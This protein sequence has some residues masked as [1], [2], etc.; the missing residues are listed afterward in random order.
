[1]IVDTDQ[2][3]SNEKLTM[4]TSRYHQDIIVLESKNFNTQIKAQYLDDFTQELKAH[5]KLNQQNNRLSGRD[6]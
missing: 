4:P 6:A 2:F 5:G 3:Q 1:M